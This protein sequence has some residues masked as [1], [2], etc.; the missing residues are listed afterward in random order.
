MVRQSGSPLSDEQ[1]SMAVVS[2]LVTAADGD[3]LY[4]DVYLRR[5]SEL[6]SPI[7]SEPQWEAMVAN[8]AEVARLR[9]QA[10]LAVA[11]QEWERVRE[12]GTRAAALRHSVESVQG[13]LAVAEIVYGAPA[14]ALDPLSPGLLSFCRRWSQAAQAR[15]EV[16]AALTALGRE[17]VGMRTLYAARKGTLDGLSLQGGT[18]V[19]GNGDAGSSAAPSSAAGLE[20]QVLQAIDRGDVAALEQLTAAMSGSKAP[21]VSELAGDQTTSTHHISVPGSLGEPIP[22]GGVSRAAALGL[23]RVDAT[24][25]ESSL[26]SAVSDFL[27]RYA[28][29]ASPAAFERASDGVA[30]IAL[31]TE[32]AGLPREAAESLAGNLSLLAL[33]LTVNSS[34]LRYVPLPAREPVLIEG[35]PEGDERVTP[36]LRELGLDRRRALAR[37][38]IERALLKHAARVL[39]D[40]LGLDAF[41]FRLVCIPADLYA[42]IGRERGWGKRE[43]WTHFDGYQVFTG[44]R[45][46]A[47]VGGHARF[48]GV[49]DVCS[50]SRDDARENTLVRFA[51]VRRDRLGVRIA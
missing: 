18:T 34:G 35:H 49:F 7:V 42:R 29:G 27:E 3:T 37:D 6:L 11:H 36:L 39:V 38:D 23:E 33:H 24:A 1:R 46:R 31:A 16:C 44:G 15:D 9:A 10:R 14:V 13:S 2:H 47:L 28:I 32:R 8:R 19:G 25:V 51:V 12:L 48:G 45:L 5:A 43:E 17:D 26:A 30:Q 40:H 41:T 4:R 50:I 21:A 20:E 22:E